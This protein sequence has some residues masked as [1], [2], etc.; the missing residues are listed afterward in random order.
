M[1]IASSSFTSSITLDNQ[2]KSMGLSYFTLKAASF[3][4]V[5]CSLCSSATSLRL[6]RISPRRED[7]FS[8]SSTLEI[9]EGNA[10]FESEMMDLKVNIPLERALDLGWEI[11][12]K[13]FEPHEVG[14]RTELINKFWPKEAGA[15]AQEAVAAS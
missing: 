10:V 5:L 4:E 15:K 9:R 11:M 12:A 3:Q 1:I 6:S 14:M 13:C 2:R 7:D 8:A